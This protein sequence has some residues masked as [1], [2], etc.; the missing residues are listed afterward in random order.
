MY[1]V[2]NEPLRDAVVELHYLEN[3]GVLPTAVQ[4]LL[5]W[6]RVGVGLARSTVGSLPAVVD[7]ATSMASSRM[8]NPTNRERLLLKQQSKSTVSCARITKSILCAAGGALSPT[9]NPL[10]E[11]KTGVGT[12]W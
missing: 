11:F 8:E 12:K 1:Q 4:R 2:A 3:K 6:N 7:L 10:Q 5:A 9:L